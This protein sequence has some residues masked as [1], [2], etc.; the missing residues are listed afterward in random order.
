MGNN[1]F[2]ASKNRPGSYLNWCIRHFYDYWLDIDYLQDHRL[3]AGGIIYSY[4]V[5]LDRFMDF[6][7][8][9]FYPGKQP[10]KLRIG[11]IWNSSRPNHG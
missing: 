7:T 1:W 6:R 5:F 11:D 8:E 3:G 2:L 9:R 10:T 4:W